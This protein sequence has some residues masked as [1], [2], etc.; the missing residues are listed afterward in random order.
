MDMQAILTWELTG[1]SGK[2]VTHIE[3]LYYNSGDPELFN[4]RIKKRKKNPN[5]IF[6]NVP[7]DNIIE[8]KLIENIGKIIS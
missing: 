5:L 7:I 3:S 6:K 4:D 1:I 8:V 2:K